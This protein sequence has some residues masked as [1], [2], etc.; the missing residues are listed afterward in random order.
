MGA[1]VSSEDEGE[2]A[3]EFGEGV[4][5]RDDSSCTTAPNQVVGTTAVAAASDQACGFIPD[6]Q[7]D[8]DKG[9]GETASEVIHVKDA[10]KVSCTLF[11]T[12]SKLSIHLRLMN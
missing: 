1:L 8:T 11:C 12:H 6:G 4:L 2:T 10:L 7:T 3:P 5:A 9:E